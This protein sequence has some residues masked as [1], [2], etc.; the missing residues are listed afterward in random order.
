MDRN[1]GDRTAS[2]T[3]LAAAAADDLGRID[4]AL[5]R[6]ESHLS[7]MQPSTVTQRLKGVLDSFRRT[8]NGWATSPPS[9]GEA[10]ALRE[11]VEQVL[12]LASSE[13]PTV[14]L[15]RQAS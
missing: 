2:G 9:D 6:A 4:R 13:S 14:R 1:D 12:R 10:A 8:V 11:Q 3:H 7:R 5:A 15:R